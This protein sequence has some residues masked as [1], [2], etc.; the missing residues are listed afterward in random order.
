VKIKNALVAVAVALAVTLGDAQ[1]Y[2]LTLLP[3]LGGASSFAAAVNDTGTIVGSS[4]LAN[5]QLRATSWVNGTATNLGGLGGVGSSAAKGINASG[6]I[7]G[8]SSINTGAMRATLWSDSTIS[9]L[10]TLGGTYSQAIAINDSGTI[11]GHSLVAGGAFHDA[12]WD[13]SGIR[14]IGY[15]GGQSGNATAIN[16]AGQIVGEMPP[17]NTQYAINDSGQIAG[18]GHIGGGV[19]HALLWDA[20]NKID[21][22]SFGGFSRASGINES[23]LVVGASAAEKTRYAFLWEDGVMVNL[24]N[25]LTA[26]ERS[27]GWRLDWANDINNNGWIVGDAKNDLTG[28]Y[29]GFVLAPDIPPP[30]I[31]ETCGNP[32][33]IGAIPEPE[34]YAMLLAGL[35]LLGLTA[36]RRKQK[37]IA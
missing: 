10:G 4:Y 20:G 1:A 11:L 24:N 36:R 18:M 8:Y 32:P 7:V 25:F 13:S 34:T 27:A 16:N 15:V 19:Y 22:G 37:L 26:S 33:P 17:F 5:G 21:L 23:G 28:Q 6:Q 35:G 3:T 31:C 14:D 12:L 2:T 29:R 9:N 30:P